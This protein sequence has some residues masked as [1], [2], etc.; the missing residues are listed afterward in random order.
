M[1]WFRLMIA[2]TLGTVA[3]CA[4]VPAPLEGNYSEAVYPD[5]ATAQSTGT[6]VR[7]GGTVV[8]TRPK[9]DQTCIEI[10]ALELGHRARP[11]RSDQ[12]HGR[13]IACRSEFIDPEIFVNGREVTVTGRVSEFQSAKVGEFDYN[14]PVVDADSV[15]LWPEN[16][17]YEYPYYGRGTYG[18]G[19]PYYRSYYRPYSGSFHHRRGIRS[20]SRHR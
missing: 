9:A 1:K 2:V 15:Y 19:Y 10:L 16:D 4:T 8:E 18:F 20:G 7:W 12:E 6:S 17:Q 14:Y 13:F 3:G 5:Q 11:E